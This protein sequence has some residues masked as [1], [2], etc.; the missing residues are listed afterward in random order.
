MTTPLKPA[1]NGP[2]MLKKTVA[3][4]V[5]C[6]YVGLSVWLVRS[7]GQ[8]FRDSLNRARPAQGVTESRAHNPDTSTKQ[9][10]DVAAAPPNVLPRRNLSRGTLSN[11]A[12]WPPVLVQPTPRPLR[13]PTIPNPSTRAKETENPTKPR[14]SRRKS[15][16]TSP[17]SPSRPRPR[18]PEPDMRNSTRSGTNRRS[19]RTGIWRTSA[20]RTRCAWAQRSTSM[21]LRFNPPAMRRT[22]AGARFQGGQADPGKDRPKRHQSTT[23]QSSIPNDVNA[24][25]HP[26]GHVYLSRG[27]IAFIG[28]EDAV[29]QFVLRM[30]SPTSIIRTCFSACAIPEF[31]T[32]K[33]PHSRRSTS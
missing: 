3:A 2:T 31:R 20:A 1:R 26:G 23:S 13:P 24:F 32:S 29:L 8:S 18:R 22:I 27:M 14:R 25:S 12:T 17:P 7:E 33:W 11:T 10:P 16:C 5:A 9:P 28:E 4:I 21:I 15:P 6:L 30:R 19:R